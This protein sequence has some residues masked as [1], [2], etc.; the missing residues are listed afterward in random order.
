VSFFAIGFLANGIRELI[1]PE[2]VDPLY[3]PAISWAELILICV[4]SI[5]SV[6]CIIY[7]LVIILKHISVEELEKEFYRIQKD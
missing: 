4:L 5:G 6:F 3:I 1:S 2:W 7:L